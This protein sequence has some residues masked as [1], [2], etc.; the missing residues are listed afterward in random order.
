MRTSDEQASVHETIVL[1][2]TIADAMRCKGLLYQHT[3]TSNRRFLVGGEMSTL[4]L[5]QQKNEA[6]VERCIALRPS[7]SVPVL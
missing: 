1:T 7:L 6:L 3:T 4:L 2:R 5:G